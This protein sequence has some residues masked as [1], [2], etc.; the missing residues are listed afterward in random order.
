MA[1]LPKK[2]NLEDGDLII[3]ATSV[4][5][6]TASSLE[7]SDDIKSAD[8]VLRGKVVSTAESREQMKGKITLEHWQ[9]GEIEKDNRNEGNLR[10]T[11]TGLILSISFEDKYGRSFKSPENR[12]EK[13]GV[14]WDSK[15][16]D[17]K[18]TLEFTILDQEN[19][20]AIINAGN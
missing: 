5:V 16:E 11:L 8:T 2:L 12:F 19:F 6:D 3:G 18:V 13:G 20:E 4:N 9:V 14:K 7:W 15:A 10:G 17:D 1:E